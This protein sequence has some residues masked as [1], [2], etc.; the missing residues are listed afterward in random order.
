MKKYSV[1]VRFLETK[2]YEIEAENEDKAFEKAE[3]LG[4]FEGCFGIEC[5]AISLSE[6]EE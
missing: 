5:E 3:E 6:I 2:E 1:M 4:N